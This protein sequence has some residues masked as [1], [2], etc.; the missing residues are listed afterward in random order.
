MK[1]RVLLPPR[2]SSLPRLLLGLFNATPSPASQDRRT[3]EW[4]ASSQ[5]PEVSEDALLES[6]RNLTLDAIVNEENMRISHRPYSPSSIKGGTPLGK[7]RHKVWYA[8]KSI[9]AS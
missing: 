7:V 5:L 2:I 3:A 8:G 9:Q 1:R 6:V 4:L